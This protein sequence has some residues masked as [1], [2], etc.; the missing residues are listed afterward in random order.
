MSANNSQGQTDP[1]EGPSSQSGGQADLPLLLRAVEQS[2]EYI[3][4]TNADGNIIYANPAL[5][6]QTGYSLEELLGQNPRIFSSGLHPRSFYDRMWEMLRSGR[7]F[8]ANWVNRKKSGELY[9]EEKNISPV[10]DGN[11]SI[12]HF[13]ATGR[14]VTER[15]RFETALQEARSSA[16]DAALA[17]SRFLAKMSHEIRTPLH[18]VLGYADLLSDSDP[19]AD[20]MEFVNIMRTRGYD[21]LALVD[22][23]LEYA[24]LEA[25]RTELKPAP[26]QLRPFSEDLLHAFGPMSRSRGIGLSLS[27]ASEVPAACL[28]DERRL[29]QVIGNLLSNG[30]KFTT[31]GTVSL[32]IHTSSVAKRGDEIGLAFVVADTG[33]GIHPSDHGSIFQA[34]QQSRGQDHSTFGGTG[35]GLSIASSLVELMGGSISLVSEPGAGSTFTVELP[36]V[37]VAASDSTVQTPV[38]ARS[39][40]VAHASVFLGG[41]GGVTGLVLYA[42]DDPDNCSLVR[43]FLK[44]TGID[45]EL[46]STGH[47]AIDSARK[48]RPDVILLDLHMPGMDGYEAARKI[49]SDSELKL[50]PVLML[51]ASALP[52]DI[53]RLAPF[54]DGYLTKPISRD[55]LLDVIRSYLLGGG[56]ANRLKT[57]D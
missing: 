15:K 4:I 22:D 5:L 9:W 48:R 30:I 50:I 41:S 39:P 8:H 57:A 56:E 45:L 19:R 6:E 31:K 2:A 3:L 17:K 38:G 36:R 25:D 10:T 55:S 44:G 51:S 24:T 52:A 12:T 18:A 32:E 40:G 53:K 7:T 46:A 54:S 42:D 1:P 26:L 11:G 35:L 47:E 37:Q 43:H 29:R 14:D 28:L 34:F 23:V 16:E 33:I 20:Q 49:K 21:L 13:I 27:V